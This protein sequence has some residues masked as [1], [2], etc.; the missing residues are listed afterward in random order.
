MDQLAIERNI[1]SRIGFAMQTELNHP[2]THQQG[3]TF[4]RH[5]TP[6]DAAQIGQLTA[7]SMHETIV[8]AI[9]RPLSPDTR[10]LFDVSR[11]TKTWAETLSALP[12]TEHQVF[13]AISDGE[14]RGLSA[15]VPTTPFDFPADHPAAPELPQTRR[16]FEITN[17]DFD[18]AHFTEDHAARTLAAITDS[19]GKPD[20]ELYLWVFPSSENIVRFLDKAGFAPLGYQRELEIDGCVCAQHLWWTTL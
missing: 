16:A 9:G 15:I 17:F 1:E 12:S 11:F 5:A 7:R 8:C 20:T 3:P 6:A 19:I 4:V 18:S 14:I 2:T 10:A 13:V